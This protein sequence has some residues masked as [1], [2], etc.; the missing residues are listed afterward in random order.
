[1]LLPVMISDETDPTDRVQ[2]RYVLGDAAG[3]N[4]LL[5]V[6]PCRLR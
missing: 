5:A 3:Y 1:M 4:G 2:R 6:R